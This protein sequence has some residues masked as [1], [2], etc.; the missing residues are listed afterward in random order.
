MKL[1]NTIMRRSITLDRAEGPQR[2]GIK[3]LSLTA[4][5]LAVT[6]ASNA[7]AQSAPLETQLRAFERQVVSLAEAMPAD[8]YDF[9]PRDGAFQDVRTF[10]QQVTH[11]ATVIY[12]TSAALLNTDVP[13]KTGAN[14]NGPSALQTKEARLQYLKDA[15]TYAHKALQS[16][17]PQNLVETVKGFGDGTTPRVGLASFEIS[18]GFDHYGQMVVYARM[19]GIIPPASRQ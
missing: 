12:I 11:I 10:G 4:L 2:G 19:N 15:F 17:T 6:L 8:K 16:L 9:A 13:V 3:R 18:H 7:A 5:L 1:P 14:A